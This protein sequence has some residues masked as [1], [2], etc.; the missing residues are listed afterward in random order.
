MP[1]RMSLDLSGP[2]KDK[3]VNSR[4]EALASNGNYSGVRNVQS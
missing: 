1:D 2:M 3:I 4:K